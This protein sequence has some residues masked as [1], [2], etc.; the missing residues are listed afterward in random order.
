M[1]KFP[2]IRTLNKNIKFLF[3]DLKKNCV[4]VSGLIGVP[5]MFIEHNLLEIK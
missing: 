5:E 2:S 3:F 1:E 4:L